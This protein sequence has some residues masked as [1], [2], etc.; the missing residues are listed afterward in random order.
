MAKP[1]EQPKRVKTSLEL[2]AGLW[3]KVR[4]QALI[5][6]RPAL[7][8]VEDALVAYLKAQKGGR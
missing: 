5:E 1:K 8:I 6:G 2:S 3:T 4:M 7:A